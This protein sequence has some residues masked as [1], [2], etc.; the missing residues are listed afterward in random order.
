MQKKNANNA[1]NANNGKVYIAKMTYRS[2]RK[3]SEKFGR[4]GGGFLMKKGY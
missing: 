4:G 2:F 1:N 3:I